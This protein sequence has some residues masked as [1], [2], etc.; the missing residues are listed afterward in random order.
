MKNKNRIISFVLIGILLI[1]LF[2]VS[3]CG[4]AEKADSSNTSDAN[5][6]TRVVTDMSGRKVTIPK[7]VNKVISL[8]NNT[9]VDIYTLAPD[10]LLG[11]SFKMKDT[12]K[13]YIPEKYFN[14]PTVGTT[15]DGKVDNEAILKLSPDLIVCSNEDGVFPADDIQK[16]LK[17]PVVMVT[18]DMD[19][20][21]KVYT[22]LGD[23][24]N[25]KARGKELADYSK[26]TLD[27]VKSLVAKVPKDKKVSVYYAE[28]TGLQTDISGN[29]HTEV[30][31]FA[32]GKNVA[33]ITEA[34]VGSMA[35]VSMEQVLN[36]NPQ[37]ILVG[38]A[39]TDL[40]S[41]L[42][43]DEKWAKVQAVH[44]K[45][46]YKTPAIPFNWFDRPPSA[47]RVLGAEWL[48]NLL[49][50]DY[51]KIDIKSET[52]NYYEE[53]FGIKLTNTQLNDIL[54]NAQ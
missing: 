8:S 28:M 5:S 41:T 21:D 19:K 46:V 25:E 7:E 31:D 51:V 40:Y 18:T 52:K 44:D 2:A 16:Q 43:S 42:L 34:K 22:F 35:Q 27:K 53:F 4:T 17:I 14:L 36:W 38:V 50:P 15:S 1:L 23:C 24:L 30:L 6:K 10:K 45:K 49:Y 48:A 33:D 39:K 54:K 26:K 32:G 13:D 20:T 47:V 11:L 37:V 3:G 29:V 9:T 12:A